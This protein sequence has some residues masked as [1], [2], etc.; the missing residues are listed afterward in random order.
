MGIEEEEAEANEALAQRFTDFEA[1]LDRAAKVQERTRERLAV[2]P[3]WAA[4]AAA[5]EEPW[6]PPSLPPPSPS[7]NVSA[8]SLAAVTEAVMSEALDLGELVTRCRDRRR[9]W[10]EREAKVLARLDQVEAFVAACEQGRTPPAIPPASPALSAASV[11]LASVAIA[12]DIGEAKVAAAASDVVAAAPSVAPSPPKTPA[13]AEP[14]AAA[15]VG[16]WA[17]INALAVGAT[18]VSVRRLSGAELVALEVVPGDTIR[19]LRRRIAQM[20][21]Y[22]ARFCLTFQGSVLGDDDTVGTVGLTNGSVL[23]IV[24][25]ES[26]QV[27]AATSDGA[28]AFLACSTG[29]CERLVPVHRGPVLSASY[30]ACGTW[31]LTTSEDGDVR[32]LDADTGESRIALRAALATVVAAE[33]S[34][35]S[36]LVLLASEEEGRGASVETFDAASGQRRFSFGNALSRG[37]IRVACFSPCGTQVLL[38]SGGPAA[39]SVAVVY[40]VA[41]GNRL[42]SAEAEPSQVFAA[43]APDSTG[44]LLASPRGSARS[45]D[46]SKRGGGR[47][48]AIVDGH[49]DNILYEPSTFSSGRGRTAAVY[50]AD[51]LQVLLAC[52]DGTARLFSVGE[53][54][55][56]LLRVFRGHT[57]AVLSASFVTRDG[58][59]TA[60]VTASTDGTA[61]VYDADDA[62]CLQ[63]FVPPQQAGGGGTTEISVS[64]L[65]PKADKVLLV[66][67][68]AGVASLFDIASGKC[69]WAFGG[70]GRSVLC[71]SFSTPSTSCG[72][73]SNATASAA[74]GLV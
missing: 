3:R 45:L 70:G 11:S 18:T 21:P 65:S 35:D 22:C 30:S 6:V 38:L 37:R 12:D 46:A 27:L 63:E 74:L 15:W 40:D 32:V 9:E 19:A 23:L 54:R 33:F 1:R 10:F 49:V 39:E 36:R 62:T 31:V 24:F 8:P 17:D 71:A 73:R 60:V 14:P 52:Q 51:G 41:S 68:P 4:K 66:S 42:F 5:L 56:E 69:D 53:G 72:T 26:P 7:S 47:C 25:Y 28:V 55:L 67:Q 48:L 59:A 13:A 16:A 57:G 58:A 29:V 43:W 64:R 20:K 34:P 61:R 44:L 50:S 2:P